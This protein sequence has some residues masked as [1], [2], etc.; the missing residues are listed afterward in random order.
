MRIIIT[1]LSILTSSMC[2]ADVVHWR[3]FEIHYTTFNSTLIPS[4]VARAHDIV[5]SKHRIITNITVRRDGMPVR[6]TLTGTTRN[7][8][9]QLVTLDFAEVSEAGAVYYLANLVV[10][11]R[12]MLIFKINIKPENH[13]DEFHLE[14]TR[15]Y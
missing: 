2:A 7:L 6:A 11:E 4:D 3:G 10:D 1:L 5:R 13:T 12:D 15:K 8:L 9:S 14:F